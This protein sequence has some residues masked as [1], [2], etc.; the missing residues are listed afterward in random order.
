MITLLLTRHQH[1]NFSIVR[2]IS[3]FIGITIKRLSTMNVNFVC[4]L[5]YAFAPGGVAQS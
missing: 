4:I 5:L 3:F 2:S 1:L